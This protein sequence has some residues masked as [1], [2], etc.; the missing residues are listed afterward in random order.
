VDGSAALQNMAAISYVQSALAFWNAPV[1]RRFRFRRA[2]WLK[3]GTNEILEAVNQVN[4]S[5]VLIGMMGAGKS[6]VGRCLHQQTGLTLFDTDEMVRLKFGVPITEI[7]SAHGEEKFREAETE[8][9]RKISSDQGGIVVTGGG[10]VLRKENIDLLKR[11]GT[12]VW[13]ETDK[14]TLF[15]RASRV[16][17]RPLLECK[18]P[19][20]AF[21]EMLHARLPLYAKVADIRIDTSAFTDEEVAVAVL[22]RFRRYL[23]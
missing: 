18:N 15:K 16:S 23:S 3:P 13:L 21:T 1:L 2:R 7:F 19:R 9:L 10:I 4:R 22:S 8:A 17:N 6:S 14:E 11:L 12:V 5:I 20:K